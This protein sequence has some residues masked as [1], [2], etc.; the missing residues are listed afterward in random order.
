MKVDDDNTIEQWI[1]FVIRVDLLRI[2]LVDVIS[3][4][5]VKLVLVT[6]VTL[7]LATT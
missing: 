3:V 4:V 1:H 7:D 5:N 6:K 2:H